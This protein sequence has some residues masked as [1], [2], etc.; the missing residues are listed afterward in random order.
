MA[1]WSARKNPAPPHGGQ[2]APGQVPELP[3]PSS[4]SEG[5]QHQ[6]GEPHP[7]GGD[8]QRRGVG[9]AGEDGPRGDG[10]DAEDQGNQGGDGGAVGVHEGILLIVWH[11]Y[12]YSVPLRRPPVK[13]GR[14]ENCA[15]RFSRGSRV[16]GGVLI[17]PLDE[18]RR[19]GYSK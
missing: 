6:G 8:D 15:E 17:L 7:V 10:A 5:G 2:I 18:G 11:V 12:Q 13:G 4:Q 1:K 16:F 14:E 19:G 9:H 3:P